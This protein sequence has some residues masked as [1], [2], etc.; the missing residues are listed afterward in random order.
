MPE[1]LLA[2]INGLRAWSRG[3]YAEEAAVE[4]LARA[5]G[6]RLASS[7]WP[8]VVPCDR[9]GWFW[10][11]AEAIW[12]GAGMLSGGERRLLNV[13]A[14]LVG[15]QPLADLGGTLAGL[16]RHNLG[17]VLAAFAHAGGSHEEQLLT[18]T[19]DGPAL[20]RV[21]PLVDWPPAERLAS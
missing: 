19:D 6:G 16:D 15:G 7:G 13:V 11:D 12:T 17:L 20:E 5:F 2:T 10:L 8:W 9:N 4:L 1:S 14:A 3:S 21:G 18:M